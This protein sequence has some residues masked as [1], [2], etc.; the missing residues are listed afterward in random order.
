VISIAI[1]WSGT[2]HPSVGINGI[3]VPLAGWIGG[4]ISG[5]I[6]TSILLI[7][8]VQPITTGKGIAD[9]MII[10]S[11]CFIGILF[12]LVRERRIIGLDNFKEILILFSECS[13]NHSYLMLFHP[14]TNPVENYLL[15]RSLFP[16]S[17]RDNFHG[18]FSSERLSDQSTRNGTTN[19]NFL[20]QN[21]LGTGTE[22]TANSNKS[23]FPKAT[24]ESTTDVSL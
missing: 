17:S 21:I 19:M 15:F 20:L 7:L 11:G 23:F 8:Q 3:L 22:T 6:I 5:A 14:G 16:R 2:Q 24:I 1:P 4:P 18:L 13:P 12:Y 10:I 9:G